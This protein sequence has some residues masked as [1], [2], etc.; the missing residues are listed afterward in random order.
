MSIEEYQNFRE[1]VLG[2][3]R[4]HGDVV[5]NLSLMYNFCSMH[6]LAIYITV[7]SK[8][9]PGSLPPAYV[10]YWVNGY[11]CLTHGELYIV[12]NGKT[13][14]RY[15][16]IIEKEALKIIRHTAD[17]EMIIRIPDAADETRWYW[18]VSFDY[19]VL[20]RYL[21]CEY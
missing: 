11:P 8:E 10:T 13:Y 6:N 1:S 19:D 9:R 2:D 16:L 12:R 14:S 20:K 17:N 15:K 21:V 7:Q 18:S 4:K 5:F 3:I